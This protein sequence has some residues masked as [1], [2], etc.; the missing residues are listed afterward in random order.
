MIKLD[1][2]FCVAKVLGGWATTDSD[3]EHIGIELLAVLGK[4]VNAV[5]IFFDAIEH[6]L[7]L[8]R[9]LALTELTFEQLGDGW[10]FVWNEAIE[11]L[12]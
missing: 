8:K 7:G 6:G 11:T 9:N 1:A 5:F 2:L 12:R 10:I 4:D 3:E